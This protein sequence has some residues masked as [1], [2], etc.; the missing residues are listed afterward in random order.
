MKLSDLFSAFTAR[1]KN[2]EAAS[3]TLAEANTFAASV[4]ALFT[5]AGLNLETLLA[6]GPESLKAHLDGLTVKAEQFTA[7]ET[8]LSK[9]RGEIAQHI[10]DATATEATLAAF[11][12]IF[13]A[14]GISSAVPPTAESVKT[15]FETHVAKQVTLANAKA[16]HPPVHHIDPDAAA[17]TAAASD[18]AVAKEYSAMPRGPE[19]LAFYQKHAA[20][21]QRVYDAQNRRDD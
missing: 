4:N 13:S 10:A 2:F 21:L 7:L 16:G 11:T 5:T 8:E 15:A 20:A 1:P 9:A 19:K 12:G 17:A 18:E 3:A 14:I 6:A